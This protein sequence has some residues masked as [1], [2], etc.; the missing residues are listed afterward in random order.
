MQI[1]IL[2]DRSWSKIRLYAVQMLEDYKNKKLDFQ[3]VGTRA[4]EPRF[5]YTRSVSREVY[6]AHLSKNIC[7]LKDGDTTLIVCDDYKGFCW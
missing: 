3:N 4:F 5:A 7:G 1:N 6:K 2:T